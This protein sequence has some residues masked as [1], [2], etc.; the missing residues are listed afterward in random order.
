VVFLHL[1]HESVGEV[2]GGVSL[3]FLL[4][5]MSLSVEDRE[6]ASNSWRLLAA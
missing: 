4:L 2:V 5:Y 3:G 6:S 1:F